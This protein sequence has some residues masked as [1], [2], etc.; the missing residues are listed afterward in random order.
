M[1]NAIRNRHYLYQKRLRYNHLSIV[2]KFRVEVQTR[3][4]RIEL[5]MSCT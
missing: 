1:P 2:D 5:G 4:Q 3:L